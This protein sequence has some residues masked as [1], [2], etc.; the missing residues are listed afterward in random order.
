MERNG[1]CA[2][3]LTIN[4]TRGND[5]SEYDTRTGQQVKFLRRDPT[6]RSNPIRDIDEPFCEWNIADGIVAVIICVL[7]VALVVSRGWI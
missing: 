7:M 4:T 5:M 1:S 2:S 6:G 3:G